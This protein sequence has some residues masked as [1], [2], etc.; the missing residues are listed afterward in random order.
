MMSIQGNF[1]RSVAP[2]RLAVSASCVRFSGQGK[3]IASYFDVDG[4]L[5]QAIKRLKLSDKEHVK[6]NARVL[7][8]FSED[9]DTTLIT[10]RSLQG[11]RETAKLL[12]PFPV[13]KVGINNGQ[14]LYVNHQRLPFHNWLSTLTRE[15]EDPQWRQMLAEK[16]GWN[17][18]TVLQGIQDVL[19]SEGF[20]RAPKKF[21]KFKHYKTS[22]L[23]YR[24]AVPQGATKPLEA[25]VFAEFYPDQPVFLLSSP[26]EKLPEAH[27]RFARAMAENVAGFLRDKT[28]QFK[29]FIVDLGP[30]FDLVFTPDGINKGSL[31]K[32]TVAQSLPEALVIAGD[33]KNDLPMLS[34]KAVT[35]QAGKTVPVHPLLSGNHLN[36]ADLQALNANAVHAPEQCQLEGPLGELFSKLLRQIQTE[37]RSSS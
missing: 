24:K 32:H 33:H 10:G 36:F 16:H 30:Y 14:E 37:Q 6:G 5:V 9:V 8:A 17:V 15:D 26:E 23:F 4:T 27:S 11:F 12:P 3:P 7:N 35:N 20:V 34:L 1:P 18:D 29:Q 22:E 19:K 21:Q 31:V 28:V 13:G 2:G 25:P